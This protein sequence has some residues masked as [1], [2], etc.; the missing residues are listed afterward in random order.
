MSTGLF[1]T[2]LSSSELCSTGMVSGRYAA[3][4]YTSTANSVTIGEE[5]LVQACNTHAVQ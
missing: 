5:R 3:T 4:I 2:G 1:T